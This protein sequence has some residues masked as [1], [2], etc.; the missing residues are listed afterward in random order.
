MNFC[1]NQCITKNYNNE[2][3]NASNFFLED[4]QTKYLNALLDNL[5]KNLE[6][7]MHEFDIINKYF[8]KLSIKLIIINLN[9]DVF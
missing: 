9:D 1:I 4:S 3:L 5:G 2:Y 6:I 7:L 8:S